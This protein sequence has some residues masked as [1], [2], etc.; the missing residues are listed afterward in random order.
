MADAVIVS[1]DTT[2][3]SFQ[4]SINGVISA[5]PTVTA[6][7]TFQDGTITSLSTP[8]LQN[9]GSDPSYELTYTES[10]LGDYRIKFITSDATCDQYPAVT[11]YVSVVAAADKTGYT[12]ADN[13]ITS[14]KLDS[15]AIAEIQQ[16]LSVLTDVNITDIVDNLLTDYQ[17]D[18]LIAN[19]LGSSPNSSSIFG[20]NDIQLDAI[21]DKTDHIGDPVDVDL[22]PLEDQLTLIQAKTDLITINNFTVVSPNIPNTT[23]VQFII[24]SDYTLT[25]G[26]PLPTFTNEDWAVFDLTSAESVVIKTSTKGSSY[27]LIKD[28]IIDSNTQIRFEI[29]AEELSHFT[30]SISIAQIETFDSPH[31]FS[32]KAVLATGDK[33]TLIQ[34]RIF[35]IGDVI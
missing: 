17:L 20:L 19:P 6:T 28:A 24:D 10:T 32:I 21:Q 22:T 4:F 1:G 30:P 25:S 16:G 7:Q 34:G 14:N 12:L 23:D 5:V 2:H 27:Q 33:E 26:Q 15:T 29:T 13:S 11:F 8:S 3:L 31:F 18:E 9:S 35:L